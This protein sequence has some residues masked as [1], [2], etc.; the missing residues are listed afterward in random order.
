MKEKDADSYMLLINYFA[1]WLE[2]FSSIVKY[3][4]FA[5]LFTMYEHII[6]IE[7][8][9]TVTDNLHIGSEH[10]LRTCTLVL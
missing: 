8:K 4:D 10:V 7:L 2:Y 3:I 5:T 1:F 9:I 6:Y